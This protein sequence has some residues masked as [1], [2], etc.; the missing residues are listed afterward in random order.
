MASFTYY[1]FVYPFPEYYLL[2]FGNKIVLVLLY[3]VKELH[4]V[5]KC[6]HVLVNDQLPVN[7]TQKLK[8]PAVCALFP[9]SGREFLN[10]DTPTLIFPI[11][12]RRG[13]KKCRFW[14]VFVEPLEEFPIVIIQWK[15]S[16]STHEYS[17]INYRAGQIS[18]TPTSRWPPFMC[19]NFVRS[20]WIFTAIH[21]LGIKN[22]WN[23]VVNHRFYDLFVVN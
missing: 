22:G 23:C 2:I 17:E 4:L 18:F 7:F 19:G 14:K 5:L 6:E 11:F 20:N 1:V 9:E 12:N 21:C 3:S 13:S 15:T 10:V 8:P 16:A